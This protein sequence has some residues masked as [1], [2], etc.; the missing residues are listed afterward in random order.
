VRSG[1]R[2]PSQREGVSQS[3]RQ[4]IQDTRHAL[5][6]PLTVCRWQLETLSDDPAERRETI[7]LV[8]DELER[9]ER[10]L[11]D[12]GV[13]VAADEPDF[14][15]RQHIDL[16]L[17]AHELVAKAGAIADRD[18]RLDRAEGT[19]F[20]DGCRLSEA[21]MELTH[22]AV[23]HTD[24]QDIVAIGACLSDDEARLWVRD[25]GC[26]ISSAD[27][28]RILNTFARGADAHRRYRGGGLGLAV[29]SAIAEAHGGRVELES[30]VGE[31]STF[32]IVIPARD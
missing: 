18:W 16:E 6:N 10:L 31:G 12:L 27:Q 17:F 20:A 1:K 14:L 19:I 29:V 5:R 21:L 4:L 25:T 2:W 7:A 3:D 13:L 22:N 28:A 30:R 15:R 26:G 24:G 23:Q 9:M 11:E 32:I 8:R